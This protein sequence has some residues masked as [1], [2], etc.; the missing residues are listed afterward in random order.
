MNLLDE[1][2]QIGREFK[3]PFFKPFV[4]WADVTPNEFVRKLI[5]FGA[6]S[7]RSDQEGM[8]L[9]FASGYVLNAGPWRFRC[10]KD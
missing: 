9:C 4:L 5:K 3:P 8:L 10:K 6:M 2:Y 1:R 7:P